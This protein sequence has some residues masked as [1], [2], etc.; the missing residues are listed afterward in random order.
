V[1]AELPDGNDSAYF[2]PGP[3]A[4]KDS[5]PETTF[6]PPFSVQPLSEPSKVPPGMST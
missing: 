5:L 1:V 2:S 3:W 4:A 6:A